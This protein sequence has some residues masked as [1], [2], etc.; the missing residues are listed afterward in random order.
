[1]VVIQGEQLDAVLPNGSS[2]PASTAYVTVPQTV[3]SP[4][5]QAIWV[6]P[7]GIRAKADTTMGFGVAERRGSISGTSNQGAE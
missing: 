5:A 2:G 1:V 6:V 4:V 7:P 3:A